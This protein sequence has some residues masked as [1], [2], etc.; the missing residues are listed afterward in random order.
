MVDLLAQ[1]GITDRAV[2][3]AFRD[4]PREKFID[5]KL[6]EFAYADH[7]LPISEDQTISQPYIVAL[8]AQAL[9]LQ[10][11][12]R[13]L[14]VGTGSG[15]AAAILSKLAAE[16]FTVERYAS[17]ARVAEE[18]LEKLGC[19]N[20]HVMHGDGTLG[21]PVFAPFDAIV[22]AAGG[23][24]VPEKLRQQLKIGGRLLIPVGD[25]RDQEL[26]L[27][28]ALESH[29]SSDITLERCDSCRW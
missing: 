10:P 7:P 19:H 28:G 22:V 9:E 23:P 16:V 15:Y 24:E 25:I 5:P 13:V 12:D 2:L 11:S 4:V 3:E 1:R 26:I 6:R 14:E 8:M 20:V 21:W 27:V 18:R 17:L 29:P